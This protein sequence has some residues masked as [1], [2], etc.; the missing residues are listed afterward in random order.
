MEYT[1]NG[2][3]NA[4]S[5]F[6]MVQ[7]NLYLHSLFLNFNYTLRI[8]LSIRLLKAKCNDPYSII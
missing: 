7:S 5:D 1:K 3:N 8:P 4:N 2:G 6:I